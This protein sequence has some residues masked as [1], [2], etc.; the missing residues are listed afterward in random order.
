MHSTRLYC[1]PRI[2]CNAAACLQLRSSAGLSSSPLCY[3]ACCPE[4]YPVKSAAHLCSI[5]GLPVPHGHG[6]IRR[7]PQRGEGGAVA[8]TPADVLAPGT[9]EPG[10]R[11]AEDQDQCPAPG[12]HRLALRRRTARPPAA[13]VNQVDASNHLPLREGRGTACPARMGS[14]LQRTP[15]RGHANGRSR[16]RACPQRF[17][18]A[19]LDRAIQRAVAAYRLAAPRPASVQLTLP[20]T[21]P[22]SGRARPRWSRSSMCNLA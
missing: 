7:A 22:G 3:F 21:G 2:N 8:M 6:C 19:G 20:R 17:A 18:D 15:S 4:Y 1:L 12:D 16:P 11:P 14:T 9:N 10:L 13:A 5:Q